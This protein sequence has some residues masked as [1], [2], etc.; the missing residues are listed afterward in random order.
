MRTMDDELQ[1][2]LDAASALCSREENEEA[3]K[4]VEDTLEKYPSHQGLM[5][6]LGIVLSRLGRENEA[7]SVLRSVLK[8]DP[9]N[10]QATS[11]L[12]RLLDNSLRTE[13][14]E[15]LYRGLLD[16]KPASHT[17]LDDLCSLLLDTEQYDEA[18]RL[19]RTHI[20]RFSAMYEAYGPLQHVLQTEEDNV[21]EG[22]DES[23]FDRKGLTKFASNLIEQFEVIVNMEKNVGRDKLISLGR[24]WDLDEEAIRVATE[25]GRIEDAFKKHR[26]SMTPALQNGIESVHA[27]MDKRVKRT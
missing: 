26:A 7:E 9:S 22:T 27:E 24:S 1:R 8:G 11:A 14:A 23:D 12:G 5:T 2:V 3:L 15:R 18:H 10:E 6:M 16:R 25:L 20:E 13:E 19:A 4:L 17:V 21:S